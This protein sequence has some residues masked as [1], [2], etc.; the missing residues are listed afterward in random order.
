MEP[1]VRPTRLFS[2]YAHPRDVYES[3]GYLLIRGFL[4]GSEVASLIAELEALKQRCLKEK[5][6]RPPPFRALGDANCLRL[7]R[8]SCFGADVFG[9]PGNVD[10][11]GHGLHYLEGSRCRALARSAKLR[12]IVHIL[13]DN[14][15]PA[16]VQ[17]K[18]VLKPAKTGSRVPP[19]TDEQYIFT[20]PVAGMA[21]WIALDGASKSN[22]CVELVDRSHVEFE[23]G[24]LFA[25][26]GQGKITWI[27]GP[28]S[29]EHLKPF[30]Y[31]KAELDSL[32]WTPVEVQP[33]DCLVMHPKVLHW[34]AANTSAQPRRAL[35]MHLI[36]TSTEWDNRNWIV[37]HPQTGFREG[38]LLP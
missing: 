25:D 24:Q 4:D 16:I 22:G 19:H 37:P 26:D 15:K 18:A 30:P 8:D 33:G 6:L 34:S 2:V 11:L 23:R 12:D 3:K 29:N 27:P 21:L 38:L 9:I 32:K 10:T 1:E 13:S 5:G 35:T 36:D 20:N 31:S 17:T 7:L 28:S 14:S